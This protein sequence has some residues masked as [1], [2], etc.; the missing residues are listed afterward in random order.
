MIFYQA[1]RRK[2]EQEKEKEKENEG[3]RR[4]LEVEDTDLGFNKALLEEIE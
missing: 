4:G 2:D 3:W 1:R